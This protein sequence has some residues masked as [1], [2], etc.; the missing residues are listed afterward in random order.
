MDAPTSFVARRDVSDAPRTAGGTQRGWSCSLGRLPWRRLCGE[1]VRP[2]VSGR[3]VAGPARLCR[4]RCPQAPSPACPSPRPSGAG[5]SCG[6]RAAPSRGGCQLW[7]ETLRG[8]QR[9]RGLGPSSCRLCCDG[10]RSSPACCPG[11]TGPSWVGAAWGLAGLVALSGLRSL[12]LGFLTCHRDVGRGGS[13]FLPVWRC[14][15]PRAETVRLLLGLRLPSWSGGVGHVGLVLAAQVPSLA[16]GC[17]EPLPLLPGPGAAPSGTPG[18]R[19]MRS[20]APAGLLGSAVPP[21]LCPCVPPS[22]RPSSR[23]L[24]RRVAL[25][26]GWRVRPAAH[27]PTGR[28]GAPTAGRSVNGHWL[29]R[30]QPRAAGLSGPLSGGPLS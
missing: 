19:C 6:C 29:P 10:P 9:G 11:A 24:S 13:R 21:S 16:L 25:A 18:G 27:W 23:G 5:G 30:A 1:E 20:G 17:G 14:R 28:G 2:G 3:G 26:C 8:R 12:C 22:L 15:C 7:L 4:G